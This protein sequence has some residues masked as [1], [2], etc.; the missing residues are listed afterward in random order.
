MRGQDEEELGWTWISVQGAWAGGMA[1]IPGLYAH[2]WEG[3]S[4]G[5]E[6]Q[7]PGVSPALGG[8]L[9]LG[10]RTLG[11]SSASGVGL[12]GGS[13]QLDAWVL[14]QLSSRLQARSALALARCL[15]LWTGP[16]SFSKSLSAGVLL[17]RPGQAVSPDSALL[18]GNDTR[19]M[20]EPRPSQIRH[21]L[22]TALG[23]WWGGGGGW[24]ELC[25]FKRCDLLVIKRN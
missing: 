24:A 7:M 18:G 25:T 22:P 11:V 2:L 23:A 3:E 8:E 9:G 1:R 10:A 19:A 20:G 12:E 21:Q 4:R 6:A 17:P 5:P 14:C 13:W 15:P 16:C